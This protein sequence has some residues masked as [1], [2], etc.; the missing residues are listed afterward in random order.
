MA[1]SGINRQVYFCLEDFNNSKDNVVRN[2]GILWY[3]VGSS[4]YKGGPKA[5]YNIFRMLNTLNNQMLP[6]HYNAD[7]EFIGA[8]ATKD[9]DSLAVLIYNY[10]DPNIARNYLSKNIA[11]LNEAQRRFL[12]NIIKNGSWDKLLNKEIEIAALN[13]KNKKTELLLEKALQLNEYAKKFRD[14]PVDVKLNISGLKNYYAY[15]RYAVD[16]TC[17]TDCAFGAR[18]EKEVEVL[19]TYQEV[20]SLKPYSVNMFIFKVKPRPPVTE[21][22]KPDSDL[23]TITKA[24]V[25]QAPKPAEK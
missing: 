4:E 21:E 16:D 6:L 22:K 24:P 7:N 1:D 2:V 15:Q 3:D 17:I 19:G 18:E 23:A 14:N 12:V 9:Q 13:L 8:I 25:A 5:T 20:V 10:A 11:T